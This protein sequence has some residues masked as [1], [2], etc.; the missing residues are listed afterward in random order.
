MD[1]RRLDDGLRLPRGSADPLPLRMA[2]GVNPSTAEEKNLRER[3]MIGMGDGEERRSA[4]HGVEAAGGAAV[5]LEARGAAVTHDLDVTPGDPAGKPGAQRFHRGF[6]GG[7]TAGEMN[8]CDP[9]PRAVR[10]FTLREDAPEK[11]IAMAFDDASEPID[12]S[13]V[14][15]ESNNVSHGSSSA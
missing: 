14:D 15:A 1:E 8:R 2:T 9:T 11:P 13:G 3:Q 12:V 7:E 4:A 10:D 5:Q 6:F